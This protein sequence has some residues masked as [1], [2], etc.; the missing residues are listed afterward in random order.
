[1]AALL[2]LTVVSSC[3]AGKVRIVTNNDY[4]ELVALYTSIFAAS[5]TRKSSVYMAFIKPL[6][7]YQ[8]QLRAQMKF[9]IESNKNEYE[10]LKK[11]IESIKKELAKGK[12][13]EESKL[14]KELC[15]KESQLADFDKPTELPLLF[16]ETD[17]TIESLAPKIKSN[18]G[19]LSLFDHEGAFWNEVAGRYTQG[20]TQTNDLLL[21]GYDGSPVMVSRV[22]RGDIFIDSCC[23][24]IGLIVQPTKIEELKNKKDLD[25]TGLIPRFILSVP[26][27]TVG[28]RKMQTVAVSH[29]A[30]NQYNAAICNL[31]K[32]RDGQDIR[33]EMT[34]KAHAK[35][36]TYC[37]SIEKRLREASDLYTIR[38]WAN[39]LSGRIAR[40]ATVL[41][42][43]CNAGNMIDG[44]SKVGCEIVDYAL[45]LSDYLIAHAKAAY[46]ILHLSDAAKKAKKILRSLERYYQSSKCLQISKGALWNRVKNSDKSMN[47]VASISKALD[48]L[49]DHNLIKPACPEKKRGRPAET[50]LLNPEYFTD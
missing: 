43:Y 35:Y 6:I 41:H 36:V 46:Q 1:M 15:E 50:Y 28:Y 9:E 16:I 4:T 32:I 21:K 39:K 7:D 18:S 14:R 37:E 17:F 30:Y 24:A 47:V 10:L 31:L 20:Q 8:K 2:L 44:N 11:R 26:K 23:L 3:L 42:C 19:V 40:I 45:S 12:V 22:M 34:D 29:Y 25:E 5:G 13:K 48:I 49:E 33:L 38:A 27:D